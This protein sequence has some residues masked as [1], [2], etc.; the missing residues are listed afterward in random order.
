LNGS[1]ATANFLVGAG[2]TLSF[3]LT[4][5]LGDLANEAIYGKDV[6]NATKKQRDCS[7]AFAAGQT[8]AAVAEVALGAGLLKQGA[9]KL[10]KEGTEKLAKNIG[11]CR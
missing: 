4:T 7:K 5:K 9:K 6:A 2:D 8:T 3:G 1:L 11:Y 10:A